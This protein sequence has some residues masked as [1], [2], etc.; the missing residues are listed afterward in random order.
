M[1]D[2]FDD[3]RAELFETDVDGIF[4]QA[5]SG[6]SSGDDEG[7]ELPD[8][9]P[10]PY[11][12][13]PTGALEETW[14]FLARENPEMSN[15]MER[16]GKSL[17]K[18]FEKYG[19]KPIRIE[20]KPTLFLARFDLPQQGQELQHADGKLYEGCLG[21]VDFLGGFPLQNQ[22][23]LA[24][25]GE[26]S[27]RKEEVEVLKAGK[28]DPVPPIPNSFFEGYDK[29]RLLMNLFYLD[30]EG[31]ETM[32]DNLAGEMEPQ[33]LHWWT[34]I[35]FNRKAKFPVPGE[36]TALIARQWCALPWGAQESSPYMFSGNWMDTVYLT[37][38]VVK[39]VDD[40]GDFPKYTVTWRKHECTVNPTDF[41]TYRI[42]DRVTILKKAGDHR[43][44]QLWRDEDTDKFDEEGWV[45]AP[46]MFY[47]I[48]GDG[49]QDFQ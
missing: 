44:S 1:T 24:F 23:L 5:P 40:S 8:A 38:A 35:N 2:I 26:W 45:I 20:D 41:A 12:A 21:M 7:E 22:E 42:G 19:I 3:I 33:G 14:W 28:A 39:S 15:I 18:M 32:A 16:A 10:D 47:G 48:R 6:P 9:I 27:S 34:R 31:A 13:L 25:I 46:L 17:D 4:A 49:G 29:R 11:K 30:E 43:Q 37:G 36:F